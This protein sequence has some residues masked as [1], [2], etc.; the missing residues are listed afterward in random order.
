MRLSTIRIRNYRSILDSGDV[1]V[2]PFQAFVGE[3]NAGKSN[4][5]RAI[6]VFLASGAGGVQEGHFFDRT[7]PIVIT[8]TF[9]ELGLEERKALRPY[10]LG[11]KLILEK[12][13]TLQG[14]ERS[15]KTKTV[16]E[17]HGYLAKPKI[18][19]L[20]VEE[21]NA[22][23]GNRPN[24]QQIAEE[25]GI[26]DYAR[27]E[28]G[29][30]TKTS[31]ESGLRRLLQEREDIEYEEPTLGTTQALGFQQ[32]L[33]DKL[34]SFYLL[35]AI[36]D[37]SS[38][39]DKRSSS[40]VYRRLMADLA[41]RM[42]KT[43]CRYSLVEASLNQLRSVL[44]SPQEQEDRQEELRRLDVLDTIEDSLRKTIARLMP[45]VNGVRL[46]VDLEDTK[47]FFARGV[48]LK[49]DDGVLT[50]VLEK[51]HGL[52]RSVVFGLLQTLI[53][54]QRDQL[55]TKTDCAPRS[56]R[57]IILAI[58]EPELYIHPQM[59]R[60]VFSVLRD[61]SKDDQVIYTTHSPAFVDIAAYNCIGVVRKQSVAVGTRVH[62]CQHGVLGSTEDRKG[63]QFLNSFGLEQNHMFF[64]R[65]IVLVE[66]EQDLIAFV[67]AG[68]KIKLFA[69]FPEEIGC[70]IV[71]TGNKEETPKFQRILNSFGLPYAVLLELDGK[72]EA[73][74]K[75]GEIVALLNG[76]RCAKISQKLEVLAGHN[77]H[78]GKTYDAKKYFENSDNISPELELLAAEL[79][80]TGA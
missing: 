77:G 78:F 46:T 30:V 55:Q 25:N 79:F 26:L 51:G 71:I 31:Y 42:L 17:Y 40:A 80:G 62:Q 14:D 32:V 44:N 36:T 76:N 52:Q 6:D 39:I 11:D 5:V 4:I 27:Q 3:N 74:G 20:S 66:G 16:S 8:C 47:D 37:Y 56:H 43:D 9:S 65:E 23:R 28:D 75:S 50:D 54:N 38:E 35:P 2:E 63:F 69:E 58:E 18:W 72:S 48:S 73:D 34:P 15:G 19:W 67:A 29:K 12:R 7:Q 60:L 1:R 49:V 33:L 64:A 13:I 24:W 57:P 21:I 68:R 53:L 70:T 59:Q 10:L 41:D 61:F 22:Q 45:S